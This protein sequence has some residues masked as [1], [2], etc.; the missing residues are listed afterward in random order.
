MNILKA[1]S[2]HP[3][4]LKKSIPDSQALRIRRI[5]STF[6]FYDCHSTKL[7]EQFFNKEYK[8]D[9]AI[10]QIQKVDQLNRKQLHQEKLHDEQCIPLSVTYNRALPNLKDILTKQ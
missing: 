1:K 3:Y 8:R 10:R 6:Q 2:E 9:V 4:S 5:C 7:I